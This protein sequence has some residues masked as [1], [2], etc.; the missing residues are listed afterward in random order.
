MDRRERM[1]QVFQD[2]QA[3][4]RENETLARAVEAARR[5]SVLYGLA[6]CPSLP[7][8]GARTLKEGLVEVS[9]RRSLEAA[10][11]IRKRHPKAR[12]GVLNFASA[13]CPGGGVKKGSGAQEECLCRCSTLYPALDQKRMWDGFYT[14]NRAAGDPLH[15]DACIYT[16]GVVICKSDEDLPRRLAPE[17]F[18]TV[19]VISCAAPDLRP[20]RDGAPVRVSRAELYPLLLDRARHILSV[21][22]ANGVDALVLGAFG[23]GVFRND[24]KLVAAAFFTELEQLHHRFDLVEFAVYCPGEDTANYDAFSRQRE[25]LLGDEAVCVLPPEENG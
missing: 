24:P 12:I 3:F 9:R 13:A 15:T 5:D 4:Y 23:C 20:G 21:A 16:P 11:A 18:V 22:V 2:T 7:E 8:E 19:D 17:D 14:P 1:V 6:D 25:D 10:V